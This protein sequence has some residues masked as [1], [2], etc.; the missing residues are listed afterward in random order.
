MFKPKYIKETYVVNTSNRDGVSLGGYWRRTALNNH[1]IRR[2][3]LFSGD[4]KIPM[5]VVLGCSQQRR[6]RVVV[7]RF[8]RDEGH[9]WWCTAPY[10]TKLPQWWLIPLSST[11]SSVLRLVRVAGHNRN[12]RRRWWWRAPVI[13]FF[14]R[15]RKQQQKFRCGGLVVISGN[16]SSKMGRRTRDPRQQWLNID[17]SPVMV[18]TRPTMGLW[19]LEESGGRLEGRVRVSSMLPVEDREE[20][21]EIPFHTF[22]I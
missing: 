7:R 18:A 1:R 19:R 8:S 12:T 5:A 22:T 3:W 20:T 21:G 9:N 2:R 6:K 15:R 4:V 16:N 11:N 17:D 14:F 10:S 13:L